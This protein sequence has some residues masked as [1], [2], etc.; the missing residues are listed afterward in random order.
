MYNEVL[1]VHKKEEVLSG[2]CYNKDELEDIILLSEINQT[3][4]DKYCTIPPTWST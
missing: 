4:K 3:Q 1:F 2:I